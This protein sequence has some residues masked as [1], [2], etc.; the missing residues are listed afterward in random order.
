[1]PA[2]RP[3]RQAAR[4]VVVLVLVAATSSASCAGG[5]TWSRWTLNVIGGLL[6]EQACRSRRTLKDCRS[7]FELAA[8]RRGQGVRERRVAVD[9]V[10]GVGEVL[11]ALRAPAGRVGSRPELGSDQIER[12]QYREGHVAERDSLRAR[13]GRCEPGIVSELDRR[14]PGAAPVD[15]VLERSGEV[16]SRRTQ[17][18]LREASPIGHGDVDV[19][20]R[21]WLGLV[22]LD[23]N[24]SDDDPGRARLRK[25]S[26]QSLE[27]GLLGG[28]HLASQ[29]VPA[30][31][32]FEG[33]F[34][35]AGHDRTI[36]APGP[37]GPRGIA[38]VSAPRY[39]SISSS[40]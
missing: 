7:L 39:F 37:S 12:G 26:R 6:G 5:L 31:V 24:A 35:R 28:L 21:P 32:E 20:R 9:E 1:M 40:R 16:E 18:G 38:G 30:A 27:V 8:L 36:L 14:A 29:P 3:R 23:R 25:D 4:A 15:G 22:D 17:R 10:E 34:Q 13:D 19:L 11:E 33:R 2:A